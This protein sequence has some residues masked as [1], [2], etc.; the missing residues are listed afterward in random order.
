MLSTD[1]TQC[2]ITVL[3]MLNH[4]IQWLEGDVAQCVLA[5]TKILDIQVYSIYIYIYIYMCLELDGFN[6]K[7]Y[8][9]LFSM[10]LYILLS[11]AM[12]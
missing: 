5:Q 7:Y 4:F 10:W 1:I 12:R 3:H 6:H 8:V 11:S 9:I 2:V